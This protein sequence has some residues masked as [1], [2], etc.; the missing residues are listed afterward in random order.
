MR[1]RAAGKAGDSDASLQVCLFSLEWSTSRPV[2]SFVLS[3]MPLLSTLT[4]H[5]L[6]VKVCESP[7]VVC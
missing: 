5:G 1:D 7:K 3:Q 6:E 2:S 4:M